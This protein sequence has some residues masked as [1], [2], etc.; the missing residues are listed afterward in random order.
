MNRLSKRVAT[1]LAA[2]FFL[3]SCAMT[4][5]V[6]DNCQEGNDQYYTCSE[7]SEAPFDAERPDG[8]DSGK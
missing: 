1:C 6:V 3:V 8:A 4:P 2:L 5:V 7:R